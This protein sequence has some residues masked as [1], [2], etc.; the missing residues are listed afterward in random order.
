MI[1]GPEEPRGAFCLERRHAGVGVL[2]W[3][4]LSA[5]E[6]LHCSP[7][8]MYVEAYS[9]Y[10]D[11]IHRSIHQ[12]RATHLRT[13]QAFISSPSEAS[14]PLYPCYWLAPSMDVSPVSFSPHPRVSGSTIMCKDSWMGIIHKSRATL[15]PRFCMKTWWLSGLYLSEC[16]VRLGDSIWR[17]VCS[18]GADSNLESERGSEDPGKLKGSIEAMS[19][20]RGSEQG[21]VELRNQVEKGAG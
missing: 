12:P 4:K 5:L 14:C 6:L 7:P 10:E 21:M 11:P 8:S 2:L 16:S 20:K 17:G 18:S 13:P 15:M 3:G 9:M 1:L 19:E